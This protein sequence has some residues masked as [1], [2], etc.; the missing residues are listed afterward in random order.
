MSGGRGYNTFHGFD[1]G[2]PPPVFAPNQPAGAHPYPLA[3]G[4]PQQPFG[5]P[6]QPAFP[7]P[8]VIAPPSVMPAYPYPYPYP[9]PG[10]AH[11]AM[12]PRTDGGFPGVQ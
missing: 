1:T 2:P 10:M 7:P 4:W 8:A 3:F 9:Q 11:P 6:A 5:W 12:P